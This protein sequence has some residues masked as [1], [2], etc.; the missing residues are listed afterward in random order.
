MKAP[1]VPLWSTEPGSAAGEGI[2][3][4]TTGE[5]RNVSE[6][7]D[8]FSEVELDEEQASEEL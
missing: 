1:A 3:A 8:M 6:I 7:S 5:G 4:T 2:M